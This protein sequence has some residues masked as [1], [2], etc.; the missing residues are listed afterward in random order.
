MEAMTIFS[1]ERIMMW[2]G[3]PNNEESHN[4]FSSLDSITVDENGG[5]GL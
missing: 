5:R 3:K 2:W 4:L 1:F